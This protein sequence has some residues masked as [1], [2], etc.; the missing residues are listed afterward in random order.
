MPRGPTCTGPGDLVEGGGGG[1]RGQPDL[2]HGPDARALQLLDHHTHLGGAGLAAPHLRLLLGRRGGLL[3]E[4]VVGRVGQ[5]ERAGVLGLALHGAAV[6]AGDVA[7]LEPLVVAGVDLEVAEAGQRRQVEGVR[8]VQHGA[9]LVGG[10]GAQAQPVRQVGVQALELAALDALAGQQQVHA[11][12]PADPADGQ[13]QVDEVGFGG[14]QFAELVDHHEQVRQRLQVGALL[15]AQ[16][17]VVADV[18]DVAGVLEHLLAALDLAGQRGVD[19]F[20]QARLVLQVGDHAA[21]CGRPAKGAKVAP[22]L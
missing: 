1:Q 19:A 2:P 22:P 4:R 11:D 8:G 3:T 10:E 15:G 6:G 20:D 16:R 9:R 18:G 12:G 14:E 17:G 21:T 5:R 7:R 13:E